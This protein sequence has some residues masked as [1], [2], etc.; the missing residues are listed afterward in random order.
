MSMHKPNALASLSSSGFVKLDELHGFSYL[1]IV[2][3]TSLYCRKVL[4]ERPWVSKKAK[5]GCAFML[6]KCETHKNYATT[7]ANQD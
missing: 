2:F 4:S 1:Y 6:N 5:K 3:S 7:R